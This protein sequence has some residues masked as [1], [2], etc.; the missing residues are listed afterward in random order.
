M[1]RC[2]AARPRCSTA[3]RSAEFTRRP[4][5]V[6]AARLSGA[7]G[8][9][10]CAESKP[11]FPLLRA[12]FD[13]C[14]V[15]VSAT[16]ANPGTRP[17]DIKTASQHPETCTWVR[18]PFLSS[19]VEEQLHRSPRRPRGHLRPAMCQ[20]HVYD[21]GYSALGHERPPGGIGTASQHPETEL[22]FEGPFG[23]ADRHDT[24]PPTSV[25]SWGSPQARPASLPGVRSRVLGKMRP[26]LPLSTRKPALGF[27]GPFGLAGRPGASS[28]ARKERSLCPLSSWKPGSANAPMKHNERA[29]VAPLY[30]TFTH[31]LSYTENT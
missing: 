4:R 21:A 3:L 2:I 24:M 6:Y 28:C 29:R 7:G 17:L 8:R 27:E 15:Q 14:A 16:C 20:H 9:L 18:G 30:L 22:G 23:P 1:E 25:V 12:L 5:G 11:G 19:A 31:P 10:I 13:M 26:E